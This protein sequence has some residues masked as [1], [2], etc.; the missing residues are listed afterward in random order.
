MNKQFFQTCGDWNQLADS[1][2]YSA[3]NK[4]KLTALLAQ[5]VEVKKALEEV[6]MDWL[7]AQEELEAMLQA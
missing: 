5:Q 7:A 6:E 3:E 4:E 2:L 1:E